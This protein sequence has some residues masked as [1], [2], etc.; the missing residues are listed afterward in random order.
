MHGLLVQL[1]MLVLV[2]DQNADMVHASPRTWGAFF[3]PHHAMSCVQYGF[4]IG[5]RQR[6]NHHH[7]PLPFT[8][9][10]SLCA[11]DFLH[12]STASTSICL[13]VILR[14]GSGFVL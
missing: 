10:C 13:L 4:N 12:S 8:A 5:L 2:A 11:A 9:P 6:V 1:S 14:T 7:W 3:N